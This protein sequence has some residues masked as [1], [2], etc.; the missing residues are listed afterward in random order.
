LREWRYNGTV[1]INITRA[2][3]AGLSIRQRAKALVGYLTDT[4]TVEI[5]GNQVSTLVSNIDKPIYSTEQWYFDPFVSFRGRLKEKLSYSVQ[6]NV[7]NATNLRTMDMTA[8]SA[9][10]ANRLDVNDPRF[11]YYGWTD[12][13]AL[14]NTVRVQDPISFQLSL[15]FDF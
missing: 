13:L 7:Y 5:A 9:S 6:L 10:T 14:T 8:V 4:A 1:A 3:R 12:P 11:S 15:K 2:W